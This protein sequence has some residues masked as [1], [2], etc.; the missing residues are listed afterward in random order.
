MNSISESASFCAIAAAAAAA[1]AG[2][3]R[4]ADAHVLSPLSRS[5][6]SSNLTEAAKFMGGGRQIFGNVLFKLFSLFDRT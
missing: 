5:G 1:A 3:P 6:F 2:V 4:D